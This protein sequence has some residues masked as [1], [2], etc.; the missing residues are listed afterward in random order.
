MSNQHVLDTAVRGI[1]LKHVIL[2]Q[3]SAHDSVVPISS[4]QW[5][6]SLVKTCKSISTLALS[7][8]SPLT[9]KWWLLK[10]LTDVTL[11]DVIFVF[12]WLISHIVLI[13]YSQSSTRDT[14]VIPLPLWTLH[15]GETA[16]LGT[17]SFITRI[18]ECNCDWC[19]EREMKAGFCDLVQH[20][21]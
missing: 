3:S 9:L 10:M 18:I 20:R 8:P 2:R 4:C 1:L 21:I 13:T 15:S 7:P 16:H 11:C 6:K 5:P 14:A 19:S 17:K 12:F